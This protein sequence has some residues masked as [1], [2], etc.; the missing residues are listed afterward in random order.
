MKSRCG[1]WHSATTNYFSF[2]IPEKEERAGDVLQEPTQQARM[3]VLF[4]LTIPLTFPEDDR[5]VDEE[6]EADGDEDHLG[7]YSTQITRS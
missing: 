3:F 1:G 6:D 4:G 2:R 7:D 5:S